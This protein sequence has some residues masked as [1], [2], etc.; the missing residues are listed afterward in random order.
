MGKASA[1]P[2]FFAAEGL[3]PLNAVRTSTAADVLPEA[4]LS[5]RA[6]TGWQLL[7]YIIKNSVLLQF[8]REY[9]FFLLVA[10]VFLLVHIPGHG[11]PPGCNKL[12]AVVYAHL[13]LTGNDHPL[14]SGLG[15]A[16]NGIAGIGVHRIL[17][18]LIQC[19]NRHIGIGH[20]FLGFRKAMCI[21]ILYQ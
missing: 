10:P 14:G 6:A 12:M 4:N 5:L 3:E 21:K 8:Q 11:G 20:E 13:P 15:V 9:G 2:I 17:N 16:V 1:F 18:E 7:F 19:Q